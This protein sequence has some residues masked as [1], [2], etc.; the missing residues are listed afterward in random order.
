MLAELR[1]LLVHGLLHL[2]GYDHESSAD[3]LREVSQGRPTKLR[4]K[5]NFQLTCEI[6]QCACDPRWQQR[7]LCCCENWVGKAPALYQPQHVLS[8]KMVASQGDLIHYRMDT[9]MSALGKEQQRGEI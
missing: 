9:F 6:L 5:L 1:V 2:L 3:D 4:L 8:M 7:N